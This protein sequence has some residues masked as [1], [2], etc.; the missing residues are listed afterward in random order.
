MKNQFYSN[1]GSETAL[2]KARPN[3]VSDEM[4][5]LTNEGEIA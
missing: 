1:V 3:G 5:T 2:E 4:E